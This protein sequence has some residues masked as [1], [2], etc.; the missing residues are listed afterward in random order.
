MRTLH[1]PSP[2]LLVGSGGARNFN[3][4]TNRNGAEWPLSSD[5]AIDKLLRDNPQ[6]DAIWSRNPNAVAPNVFAKERD[7]EAD[8]SDTDKYLAFHVGA[9][10]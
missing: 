6:R 4:L 2:L 7:I 5:F 8:F 1:N 10:E 3:S 9:L